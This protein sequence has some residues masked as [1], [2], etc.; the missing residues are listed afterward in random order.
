MFENTFLIAVFTTVCLAVLCIASLLNRIPVVRKCLDYL[1]NVNNTIH[2]CA[3]CKSTY[4]RR[5]KVIRKLS[6]TE[7]NKFVS[8]GMCKECHSSMCKDV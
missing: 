4:D 7:Y 5:G 8:H 1:L 2:V 3:W 6:E